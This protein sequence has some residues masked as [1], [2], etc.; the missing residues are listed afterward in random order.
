M[1]LKHYGWNDHLADSFREQ[2]AA[3]YVP[4]RVSLQTKSHYLVLT[5][6]G[7]IPASPT[8]RLRHDALTPMDMPV[9]GDWVAA[10]ILQEATP[11]A[12]IH[13]VLPRKGL[14]CRKEAGG[15][16]VA[17]PLAANVDT[18]FIA[19]AMD[20]DYS[21]NRIERYLA[22]SRECGASPVVLLTK[23]D[24]C[25]D[26]ISKTEEAM[27]RLAGVPV[28]AVSSVDGTGIDMLNEHLRPGATCAV[29][30]SSGV[31]KSTLINRLLG[32][33]VQKTRE[34]RVADD[35]GRHTT[36]NRQMFV[37]GSGALIIDTPGMRELQLWDAREGV[38]ETF[39]DIAELTHECRFPDCRHVDEPGC[40]ILAAL[41][42]GAIDPARLENYRKMTR[43]LDYL[44]LRQEEGAARLERARWKNIAKRIKQITKG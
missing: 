43:E 36:T 32:T 18:V 30:G 13:Q 6:I 29:L 2:A 33:E 17:Q 16:T 8:G 14:F 24:A 37:L 35:K 5:E 23:S 11:K 19:V 7:E 42:R 26:S 20:H 38:E 9:V 25:A 31:G 27:A 44:S 22:L 12:Q 10:S 3:G 21:L 15:L 40:A 41:E 28:I 4:V 39:Q 1:E 34:V